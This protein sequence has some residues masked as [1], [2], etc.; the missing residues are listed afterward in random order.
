MNVRAIRV[1]T[2]S[3]ALWKPL[4]FPWIA[5]LSDSA[6]FSLIRKMSPYASFSPSP[7]TAFD[8]V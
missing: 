7:K 3:L 4:N 2:L 1:A 6:G 5:A 8:R